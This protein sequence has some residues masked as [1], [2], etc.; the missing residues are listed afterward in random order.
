[1]SQVP[2]GRAAFNEYFTPPDLARVCWEYMQW[3]LDS[4]QAQGRVYID[5]SAGDPKAGFLTFLPPTHTVA[6]DINPEFAKKAPKHMDYRVGDFLSLSPSALPKKFSSPAATVVVVGNPPFSPP[7]HHGLG[8]TVNVPVQFVLHAGSLGA[9]YCAFIVPKSMHRYATLASLAKGGMHLHAAH[10]LGMVPFQVLEKGGSTAV[11][12]VGV[13]FMIWGSQPPATPPKIPF[14]HLYCTETHVLAHVQY[15][16]GSGKYT[17]QGDTGDFTLLMP[18]ET[19]ADMMIKRFGDVGMVQT[20]REYIKRKEREYATLQAAHA[21]RTYGR[22]MVSDYLL[23]VKPGLDKNG[24]AAELSDAMKHA[25]S[26]FHLQTSRA[27][28]SLAIPLMIAVYEDFKRNG[29]K[30]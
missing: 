27:G 23:K 10:N 5:P 29:P 1:M 12:K 30:K 6:V 24:V 20:S 25:K 9:K 21:N 7:T 18:F 28:A 22:S 16:A 13:T 11:R 17:Y 3:Y 19:G 8:R 26:E 2:I 15:T 4:Q 14:S